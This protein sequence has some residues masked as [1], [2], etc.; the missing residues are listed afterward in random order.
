MNSNISL[1]GAMA[2]SHDVKRRLIAN[3]S[4]AERVIRCFKP[5]S[6][7]SVIP[8]IPPLQERCENFFQETCEGC[9]DVD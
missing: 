3:K 2:I 4:R 7:A 1:A 9:D 8:Y 6:E 5:K